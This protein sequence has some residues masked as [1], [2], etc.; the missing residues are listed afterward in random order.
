M[1]EFLPRPSPRASQVR[2]DVIVV[3]TGVGGVV[4]AALLAAAGK[5]VLV[6]D[7]NRAPGGILA[8]HRR[9]FSRV[10]CAA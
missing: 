8:S 6:L 7:K 4:S 10:R 9:S 1:H 2:W 5:R 3:G